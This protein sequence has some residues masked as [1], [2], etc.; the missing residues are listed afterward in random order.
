MQTVAFMYG[1]NRMELWIQPVSTMLWWHFSGINF[2]LLLSIGTNIESGI[3]LALFPGVGGLSS[4]QNST[5]SPVRMTRTRRSVIFL[6]Q[7]RNLLNI[8][9]SY[10]YKVLLI[11]PQLTRWGGGYIHTCLR[12]SQYNE[13]DLN[14][15]SIPNLEKLIFPSDQPSRC[16]PGSRLL[17]FVDPTG[18]SVSSWH[19][20]KSICRTAPNLQT[21]DFKEACWEYY[22]QKRRG[23]MW[24]L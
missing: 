24:K 1:G 22:G 9:M 12:V 16:R 21:C 10:S 20:H 17:N 8:I 11:N 23:A 3:F 4:Q 19:G 5:R 6:K 18:T 2:V 13:L 7:C 15:N 14:W